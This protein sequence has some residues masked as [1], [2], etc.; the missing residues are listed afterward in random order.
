MLG[1]ATGRTKR[2]LTSHLKQLRRVETVV[3]DVAGPDG[4]LVPRFKPDQEDLIHLYERAKQTADKSEQQR[5]ESGLLS[6][7]GAETRKSAV[8]R[9]IRGQY[10]LAVDGTVLT[11]SHAQIAGKIDARIRQLRK[12]GLPNDP[13][14]QAT[15][16]GRLDELTARRDQLRGVGSLDVN[17]ELR[18]TIPQPDETARLEARLAELDNRWNKL[19]DQVAAAE[20]GAP[21]DYADITRRRNMQAKKRRNRGLEPLPTVKSDLRNLGESKLIKL[22]R[23][24][25]DEPVVKR[26]RAEIEEAHTIRE[27]LNARGEASIFGT[28]IPDAAAA[29]AHPDSVKAGFSPDALPEL[30]HNREGFYV[31]YKTRRRPGSLGK[32][33]QIGSQ[34]SIGV[35]RPPSELKNPYTGTARRTGDVNPDT[36]RIVA[37]QLMETN[38]FLTVWRQRHELGRLS[39]PVPETEYDIPIRP[40]WLKNKKWPPEVRDLIDRVDHADPEEQP[41]LAQRLHDFVFP[42]HVTHEDVGVRYI[43]S[44]LLGKQNLPRPLVGVGQHTGAKRVLAVTDAVNNAERLALLY[45]KPAYVTPN[46]LGNVALNLVHGVYSPRNLALAARWTGKLDKETY[47]LEDALMGEGVVSSVAG[48]TGIGNRLVQKA[49][50]VWQPLVDTR[51]R[52][53]AF[54]HE[55]RR[56]GFTTAARYKQLLTDPAH[57]TKLIEITRRAN[58]AIIDYGRMGPVEQDLVRRIVFLYPW[59]KGATVYAGHFVAEHPIQASLVGKVG[60]QGRERRNRELGQVPSWAEALFKVGQRGQNPLVANPAAAAILQTPAQVL[61]AGREAVGGNVR[62]AYDLSS[63]LNPAGAALLAGLSRRQPF[64]GYTYK[65]TDSFAKIVGENLYSGIPAYTLERRLTH[66]N[67]KSVFPMSRRDA[68]LQF[69]LGSIAPR[70]V[71]L[72]TLHAH[73]KAEQ[74]GRR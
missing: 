22:I 1:P 45:A 21:G 15:Y 7:A 10:Q 11:G 31:T 33:P 64:T 46:I 20:H 34:G 65:P 49:A 28:D 26:L 53:A 18:S 44:R 32:Q 37:Q 73:A 70:P 66:P 50:H 35:P 56:A 74:T 60:A 69:I 13:Q 55:A 24:K 5:I 59:T 52:R 38:R 17:P 25:P 48:E 47:A 63:F 62:S 39:K 58:S 23:D 42:K 30:F 19:V 27:R 67:P 51:F 16:R 3:H 29:V 57:E 14:A 8:G 9:E 43:D 41:A 71:N 54:R 4:T 2:L 12:T 40:I 72:R 68:L 36:P 6:A 61:E